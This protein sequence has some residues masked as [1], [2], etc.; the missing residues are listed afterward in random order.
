[1]LPVEGG[2]SLRFG[3]VR[4]QEGVSKEL[5]VR[6]T[7]G[8]AQQYQVRQRLLEDLRN[9]RG[10]TLSR[11][12]VT[13]YTL[14]GSNAHGTLYQDTPFGLDTMERVI[15]TSSVQ[16]NSDSFI[17]VYHVDGSK[18]NVSGNFFGRI[19]YTLIPLGGG[20]QQ[21]VIF[22]VYLNADSDFTITTESS[23]HR[24]NKLFLMPKRDQIQGFVKMHIKGTLGRAYQLVQ[25]IQAPFMNENGKMF[26]FEDIQFFV[27]NQHGDSFYSTYTP[28][29]QK[30]LVV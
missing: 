24:T 13:F 30:P 16:G 22:N 17:I 3:R 6:V 20:Q 14:R 27:T 21:Q 18:L 19:L 23:S 10:Q 28:L 29:A 12:A 9:E 25:R 26:P 2:T 8:Q 5:R 7:S 4:Q 15:Y 1:M 11:D